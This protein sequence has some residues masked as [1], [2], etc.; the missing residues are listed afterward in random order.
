M[1][2]HRFVDSVKW[3]SKC[4]ILQAR[5]GPSW[6]FSF[7]FPVNYK[8]GQRFQIREEEEIWMEEHEHTANLASEHEACGI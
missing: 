2:H 8:L 5:G 3:E 1:R 6:Y 7:S 4:L